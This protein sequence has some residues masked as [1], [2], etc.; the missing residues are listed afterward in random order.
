MTSR[1]CAGYS[2][3]FARWMI[4]PLM[5]FFLVFAGAANA[6]NL[7]LAWD[8]NTE[9]DLVGYLAFCGESSGHYTVSHEITSENPNDPPPTTWE[10]TG[11]E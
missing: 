7:T 6:A 11:L 3:Q 10:F 5:T 8:A 1:N 9:P 2:H 4:I